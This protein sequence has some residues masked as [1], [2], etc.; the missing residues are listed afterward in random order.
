[1]SFHVL[2]DL[3][4]EFGGLID[5]V[6]KAASSTLN[7]V[8]FGARRALIAE[9]DDVFDRPKPFM[10]HQAWLLT[11]A[12]KEDVGNMFSEIRAKD[13]QGAILSFQAF[14]GIRRP[15]DV[16]TRRFDMAVAAPDEDRDNYG[17][18]KRGLTKRL[19]KKVNSEKKKRRTLR[20]RRDAARVSLKNAR[21]PLQKERRTAK[22]A[23]LKW[24]DKSNNE[25]GIFRDRINGIYGFWERPRRSIAS[26]TRRRGVR[27]VHPRG[28]NK[29][30]LLLGFK[31]ETSYEPRFRYSEKVREIHSSIFEGDT[32]Q[33][34]LDRA[35][36]RRGR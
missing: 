20:R 8:L 34:E 3:R 33:R 11:K 18:I 13:I 12:K 22:L 4:R 35:I 15:G 14:G 28:R 31:R 25:P 26:G 24:L 9:A 19:Q 2:T 10:K 36:S 23:S 6:S 27:T 7:D 21:T 32:F 16:G 5:D 30:Q 17:N 29:P 1:M